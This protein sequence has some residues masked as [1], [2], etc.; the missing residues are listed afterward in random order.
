LLMKDFKMENTYLNL[1]PLVIDTRPEIIDQKEK[2]ALKKDIF[3]FTKFQND[4]LFYIGTEVTEKV[5][6]T[7]LSFYPELIVQFNE[8]IE[9]LSQNI[10]VT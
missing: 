1:S 4:R 3:L 2:F 5:D 9:T 6:L 10:P 8:M 7:T